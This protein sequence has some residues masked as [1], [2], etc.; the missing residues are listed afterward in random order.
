M[1]AKRE[2]ADAPLARTRSQPVSDG[3]A[4]D[5]P[6]WIDRHLSGVLAVVVVV[7]GVGLIGRALSG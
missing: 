3:G 5:E 7:C 1:S 2:T 6:G 4:D